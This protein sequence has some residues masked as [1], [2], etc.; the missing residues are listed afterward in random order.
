[1]GR[2]KIGASNSADLP[3][4]AAR[5]RGALGSRMPVLLSTFVVKSVVYFLI[6]V[7]I[8]VFCAILLGFLQGG[9]RRRHSEKIIPVEIKA[10]INLKAKSQRAYKG[11]YKPEVFTRTSMRKRSGI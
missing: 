3:S 1:V 4:F 5:I 2:L 9:F 7:V 6:F 10:E 11:K 8:F